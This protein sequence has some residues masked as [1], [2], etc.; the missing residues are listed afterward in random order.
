VTTAPSAPAAKPAA[1]PAADDVEELGE[2]VEE[3]GEEVEELG[4]EVEELG[5]EV[6]ELG[7]EVEE[8]GEEVEELGDEVEEL[9]EEVAEAEAVE[10]LGGADDIE[11]LADADEIEEL[12]GADEPAKSPDPIASLDEAV[13]VDAG[14]ASKGEPAKSNVKL[15]FGDDDIPVIMESSGLELVDDDIDTLMKPEGADEPEELEELGSDG[16]EPL[17]ELDE[18]ERVE[19]DV[20][21]SPEEGAHGPTMEDIASQIEFGESKVEEKGLDS[22]LEIVS[23]FS[24]MLSNFDK[25][26][27]DAAADDKTEEAPTKTSGRLEELAGEG[28]SLIYKPFQVEE[29]SSPE[30]IDADGP[31]GVIQEKDGVNFVADEVKNPDSKTEKALD[32][33]LKNLVNSVIKK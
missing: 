10:E 24:S 19:D 25:E 33:G 31:A 6:E 1:A 9:G 12:G 22:E 5:E 15:I 26:A 8:L 20:P 17:E 29:T 21:H 13:V 2:E 3:L 18:A 27:D 14:P 11:E 16:L 28:M 23:P 7:E 4:E 30:V 32:P